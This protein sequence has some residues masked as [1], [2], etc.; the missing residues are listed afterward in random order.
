MSKGDSFLKRFG[1][2]KET[3]KNAHAKVEKPD[4]K[5]ASAP[6]KPVDAGQSEARQAS[7]D[8]KTSAKSG[9]P[10]I[11]AKPDLSQKKGPSVAVPVAAPVADIKSAKAG[12]N[13]PGKSE[14][15]AKSSAPGASDVGDDFQAHTRELEKK[16]H[17][18]IEKLQKSAAELK[19]KLQE[20][21]TTLTKQKTENERLKAD[22]EKRNQEMTAKIKALSAKLESASQE[23]QKGL[24]GVQA[25]TSSEAASSSAKAAAP[26]KG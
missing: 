10:A 13:V 6:A 17:D 4:T 15:P 9:P 2:R 14:V 18:G 7:S 19:T 22:I 21:E 16:L 25:P 26:Q 8:Q 1:K 3:E 12:V 23:I 11:A 20:A 24:D 5:N